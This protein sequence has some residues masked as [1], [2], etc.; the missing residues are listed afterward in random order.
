MFFIFCRS[1]LD[2]QQHLGI[3][4]NEELMMDSDDN[5]GE[6]EVA[7]IKTLSKKEK[8][9]LLKYAFELYSKDYPGILATNL[10]IFSILLQEISKTGKEKQRD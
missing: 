8:K 5:E 3:P 1:A 4:G 10:L 7:F 9:K 2:A 6:P